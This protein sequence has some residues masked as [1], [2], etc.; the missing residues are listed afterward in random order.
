MSLENLNNFN[1]DDLFKLPNLGILVVDMQLRFVNRIFNETEERK[2]LSSQ[3]LILGHAIKNNIPTCLIEYSNVK[4]GK[5]VEEI[6]NLVKKIG[7]NLYISKSK[8]S[9]FYEPLI[10]SFLI[11]NKVKN[12]IVMGFHS[13]LC[14]KET[15]KDA[16]SREFVI[17][18]SENLITDYSEEKKNESLDFYNENCKI[19]NFD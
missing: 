7:N 9:A 8:N 5:T 10:H 2:V 6:Y 17:F 14:L 4:A 3:K 18:T 1:L 15:V 16:I 11:D 13:N 19:I 12:L